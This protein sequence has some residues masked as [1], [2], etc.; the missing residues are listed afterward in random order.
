MKLLSFAKGCKPNVVLI[1]PF[2]QYETKNRLN[3]GM[4]VDLAGVRSTHF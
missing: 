2:F 3:I 4:D 1:F